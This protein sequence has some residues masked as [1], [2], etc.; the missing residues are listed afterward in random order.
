VSDNYD[1][2]E[3]TKESLKEFLE[4]LRKDPGKY[5]FKG[6]YLRIDIRKRRL[7][8]IEFLKEE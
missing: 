1:K 6:K 8:E 3:F 5:C 4:I 2:K 7:L